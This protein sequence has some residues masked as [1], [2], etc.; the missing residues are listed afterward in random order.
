MKE[1]AGLKQP[2]L[3]VRSITQPTDIAKCILHKQLKG[4]WYINTNKTPS[5]YRAK[6]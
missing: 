1:V 5:I 3:S 2:E 4:S 6:P